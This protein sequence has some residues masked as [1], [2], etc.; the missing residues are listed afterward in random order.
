MPGTPARL[1]LTGGCQCGK[2]RYEIS[3]PLRRLFICHCREC[4][5]QSASAFAISAMFSSAGMRHLTGEVRQWSRRTES[6]WTLV[7]SFCPA[8]GSRLW[9]GD[10]DHEEEVCVKGGSL[11]APLDLNEAI[12][13][14]TCRKLPGVVIP[15]AARQYATEP[16]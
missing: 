4:Q 15:D 8:C 12:H 14:W 11:D 13:I 7:S 3:G 9:D 2:V 5:K 1:P 10:K 16:E 6:G